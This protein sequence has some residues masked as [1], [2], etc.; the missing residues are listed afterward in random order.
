MWSILH[1]P[2]INLPGFAGLNGLPI[3]LSLVGGRYTDRHTLYVG[4][5]IG[6]V[7]EAEGG[8]KHQVF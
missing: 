4:Q 2:V 5:A 1:V 7:F 6:Q 8:F 3:G